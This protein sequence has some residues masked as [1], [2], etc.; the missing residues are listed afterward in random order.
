MRM[1][2]VLGSW[3]A[4]RRNMLL[5]PVEP[6]EP[7]GWEG[8]GTRE[9]LATWVVYYLPLTRWAG[10]A[11]QH[12][13]WYKIRRFPPPPPLHLDP[14]AHHFGFAEGMAP[15]PP[16]PDPCTEHGWRPR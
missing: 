8:M 7:D 10:P 15:C 2:P 16:S 1:R 3:A 5:V 9:R 14:I 13:W 6:G 11:V 12:W 4:M